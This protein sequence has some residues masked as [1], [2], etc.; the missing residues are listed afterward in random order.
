M[1]NQ[2]KLNSSKEVIAYLAEQFPLCFIAEGEA[3]PLKIG[4]FQDLVTRLIDETCVSKTQLR[5]ALRLYTTSWRYLYGIKVGAER[6]D[7][8]GNS[9]GILE[10][11][12]VEHAKK[13]LEEAKARVQ[14]QRAERRAKTAAESGEKNT[15]NLPRPTSKKVVTPRPTKLE[16]DRTKPEVAKK[17][18]T[19]RVDSRPAKLLSVAEIANIK[20]GQNI[21]VKAGQ[22]AMDATVLEIVKGGARVQLAS[23]LA[24]IVRAEHL[25]L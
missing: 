12:H 3:K 22:S 24:M 1:E 23:G 20:I 14:A 19:K 2:P 6:I 8:D 7:L 10:E 4:I 5:T 25:Q 17:P 21:K 11:Q 13:Q 16:S 9:C 15:K 18:A